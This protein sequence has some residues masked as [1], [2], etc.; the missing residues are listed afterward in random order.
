MTF[1]IFDAESGGSILWE[2]SQQVELDDAGFYSVSLGSDSNPINASVLEGGDRWIAV[3]VAADLRVGHRLPHH[4]WRGV[5]AIIPI[6]G[7]HH[8]RRWPS[9]G[10]C[11]FEGLTFE[12]P[13][14]LDH[15]PPRLRLLSVWRCGGP[16][17]GVR[18]LFDMR[19]DQWTIRRLIGRTS[20]L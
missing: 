14:A 8:P 7:A 20:F 19:S 4:L 18:Y 11:F 16:S 15:L 6:F 1:T 9:A 10:V 5:H 13:Y 12:A 3:S 2:G 17:L